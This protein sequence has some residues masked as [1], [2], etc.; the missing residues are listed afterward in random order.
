[1]PRP[2]PPALRHP[3]ALFGALVGAGPDDP[4]GITPASLAAGGGRPVAVYTYRL[5]L[6]PGGV[7]VE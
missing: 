2:A 3:R 7:G 1:M 6:T 5:A 4:G